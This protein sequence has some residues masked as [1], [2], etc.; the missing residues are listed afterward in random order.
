M[1]LE[2]RLAEC[3][4]V[5]PAAASAGAQYTP[6]VVFEN[7]AWISGQLPRDGERVLVAGKL[8]REVYDRHRNDP[9]PGPDKRLDSTRRFDRLGPR[10]GCEA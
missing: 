10:S 2:Q 6:A 1:N 5:L 4:I 3:S 8:G 7:L 9:S